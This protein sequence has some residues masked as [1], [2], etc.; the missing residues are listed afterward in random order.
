MLQK[1]KQ[2]TEIKYQILE[3]HLEIKYVDD[4]KDVVIQIIVVGH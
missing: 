3:F 1:G 4:L 2:I